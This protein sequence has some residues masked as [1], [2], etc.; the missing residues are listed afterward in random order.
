MCQE[1]AAEIESG[2]R[3]GSPGSASALA[4][5]GQP[6]AAGVRQLSNSH[7]YR[8]AAELAVRKGGEGGDRV[9][10]SWWAWVRRNP[11][12][13]WGASQRGS[14]SGGGLCPCHPI[15]EQMTSLRSLEPRQAFSVLRERHV[16]A[17]TT[18]VL[19]AAA[20]NLS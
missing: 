4:C 8:S 9:Q 11:R 10:A 2:W 12:H 13:I 15:P 16:E 18:A 5:T 7:I 3:A 20:V 1:A 19:H 6:M 17:K 14:A